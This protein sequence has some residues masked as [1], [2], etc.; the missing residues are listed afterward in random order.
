MKIVLDT[1]VLVSGLLNRHGPPGKILDLIFVGRIELVVDE[2]ILAEYSRV[3]ARP[4]L[5][6][7]S[8]EAHSTLTFIAVTSY[9]VTPLPLD[10]PANKVPDPKDLPFAEAAISGGAKTLVTGNEKHFSFLEEFSVKV[11]NPQIF[12]K[13]TA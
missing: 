13:K 9:R 1:N 5:G 11:L 6:I 4:R 8:E 3:L 2:R 7:P 12:L 10:I